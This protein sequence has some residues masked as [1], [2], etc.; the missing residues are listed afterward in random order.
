MQRG[1]LTSCGGYNFYIQYVRRSRF[2]LV[3]KLVRGSSTMESRLEGGRIIKGMHVWLS[4]YGVPLNLWNAG[5][6]VPQHW[7][8]LGQS[9]NS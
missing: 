1:F 4:C 2:E 3:G 5:G 9:D 8:K 6:H 7:Q